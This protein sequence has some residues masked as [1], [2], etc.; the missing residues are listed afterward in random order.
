MAAP[1]FIQKE[2]AA[3]SAREAGRIGGD[4]SVREF[5]EKFYKSNTWQ[6]CREA[7]AGHVGHLCERCLKRG[8]IEPGEI[9]HHKVYLTPENINDP[10][11]SLN[12]DNLELLCRK[13]HAE[14]HTGVI[15]RYSL[16]EFGRVNFSDPP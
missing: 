1:L 6:C 15:I 13:C 5:A 7:Y 2:G 10:A 4:L 9:V 3:R 16:D 14:E 12:F 11:V 8:K